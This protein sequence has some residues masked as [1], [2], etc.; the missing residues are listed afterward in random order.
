MATHKN[1][2]TYW[3]QVKN[4]PTYWPQVRIGVHIDRK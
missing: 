1:W 3:P 2:L 4:Q